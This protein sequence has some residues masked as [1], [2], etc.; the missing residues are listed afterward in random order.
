MQMIRTGK[1][2][3][4]EHTDGFQGLELGK[5]GGGEIAQWYKA[6]FRGV[7]RVLEVD[8]GGSCTTW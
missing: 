1:S 4:R 3:D 6:L 2:T 7:K 8:G 5:S